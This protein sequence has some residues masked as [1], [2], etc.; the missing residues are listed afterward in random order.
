M[1]SNNNMYQ[2]VRNSPSKVDKVYIS[3]LKSSIQ[4]LGNFICTAFV[5]SFGG[6]HKTSKSL[7]SGVYARE[8]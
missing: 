4:N 6:Y 1:V 5:V 3:E 7:L 2:H 8:V